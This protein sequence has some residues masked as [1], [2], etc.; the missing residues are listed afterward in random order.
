M[1][2]SEDGWAQPSAANNPFVSDLKISP[3]TLLPA[4]FIPFAKTRVAKVHT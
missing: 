2:R 3:G 4:F 1:I